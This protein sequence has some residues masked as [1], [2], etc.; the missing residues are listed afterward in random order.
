MS[1][2]TQIK[3]PVI[4]TWLN[5]AVTCFSVV[6]GGSDHNAGL[7]VPDRDRRMGVRFLRHSSCGTGL[8]RRLVLCCVRLPST[9]PSHLPGRA[10]VHRER[11]RRIY[12]PRQGTVFVER[13]RVQK[14][15]FVGDSSAEI[16]SERGMRNWWY[17]VNWMEFQVGKS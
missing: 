11:Y 13:F 5:V 16:F 8:E 6:S 1:D 9:A 4:Y 7:R 17:M 10:A 14:M 12:Q 15:R 3:H 2:H